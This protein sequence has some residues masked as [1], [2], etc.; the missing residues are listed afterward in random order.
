MWVGCCL[1]EV[2]FA[3]RRGEQRETWGLF[4]VVDRALVEHLQSRG[5]H[6]GEAHCVARGQ[7]GRR[8]RLHAAC[9]VE[10]FHLQLLHDGVRCTGLTEN[11]L[12]VPLEL[13]LDESQ[14]GRVLTRGTHF[15][16]LLVVN[17][18]VS[19]DDGLA[20]LSEGGN[21]HLGTVRLARDGPVRLLSGLVKQ[22]GGFAP[23]LH[24]HIV[25]PPELLQ[26]DSLQRKNARVRCARFVFF[27]CVVPDHLCHLLVP[28]GL[29]CLQSLLACCA[30]LGDQIPG[31]RP[32]VGLVGLFF[33]FC[34]P[35]LVNPVL[36]SSLGRLFFVL[37]VSLSHSL[38]F[39]FDRNHSW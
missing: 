23:A 39:L 4:R 29:F 35:G 31:A 16:V 11:V 19:V 2:L 38:D 22:L 17:I 34:L 30:H 20:R 1:G 37:N 28:D 9:V 12:P 18:P 27:A 33:L 21:H 36:F 25:V 32:I 8:D 14:S 13:L 6:R 10:E 7:V 15:G 3:G 5:G 26:F 24:M